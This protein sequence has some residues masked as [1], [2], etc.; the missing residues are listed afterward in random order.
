MYSNIN[1]KNRDLEILD[2]RFLP[3]QK[4]HDLLSGHAKETTAAVAVVALG[5]AVGVAVATVAATAIVAVA[6]AVG[7]AVAATAVGAA[8]AATAVGVA[9]AAVAE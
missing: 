9:A 7:A 8:V 1:N 6:T 4:K 2:V 3:S 5:E